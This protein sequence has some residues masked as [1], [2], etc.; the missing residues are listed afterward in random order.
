MFLWLFCLVLYYYL[1]YNAPPKKRRV[2][3]FHNLKG[4]P[5]NA[6]L[7]VSIVLIKRCRESETMLRNFSTH[8]FAVSYALTH[9]QW[10]LLLVIQSFTPSTGDGSIM[11]SGD[12]EH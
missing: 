2:T 6:S 9:P 7:H 11:Y 3:I 10:N 1:Y 8:C 5:F 12:I 4:K